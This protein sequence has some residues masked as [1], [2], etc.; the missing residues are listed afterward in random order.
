M[1]TFTLSIVKLMTQCH[2][3]RSTKKRR[4]RKKMNKG[5]FVKLSVSGKKRIMLLS[6]TKFILKLL[7]FGVSSSKNKLCEVFTFGAWN[8]KN[9]Y[10][11]IRFSV[12]EKAV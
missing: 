12:R 7:N 2:S 1:L 6:L 5:A 9:Y 3:F 11:K 8:H 4:K 10:I